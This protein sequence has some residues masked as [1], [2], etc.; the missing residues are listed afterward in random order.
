M[1]KSS[2]LKL[3]NNF[4]SLRFFAAVSVLYGHSYILYGNVVE[5]FGRILN[6]SI[7]ELGV[8]A[9]F[10]MSGFLI[11]GSFQRNRSIL[12]YIK[13]R[14]LRIIPALAFSTI[15]AAFIIGPIVTT[16]S[17]HDYFTQR[18][19]W[20]F[21]NNATMF[22]IRYYLPGVFTHNVYPGAVNGSLWTLRHELMMYICLPLL[23]AVGLISR[24][25]ILYVLLAFF[26]IHFKIVTNPDMGRY[27][28]PVNAYHF[29]D[30]GL[31]FFSGA[32]FYIYFDKI[33]F[34]LSLCL[35]STL[36]GILMAKTIYN[37]MIWHICL[38]YIIIFLAYYN[39]GSLRNFGKYGDF[40]Y[41][42][43]V[44]AFPIQQTLTFFYGHRINFYT[45]ISLVF[46]LTLIM[47]VISWHLIEKR[48]LSLKHK[49]WNKKFDKAH[50]HSPS[51]VKA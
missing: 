43:Y 17:L 7:S 31:Y 33:P 16:V 37:N 1:D 30:L 20:E 4:D 47:A 32:F 45:Y 22:Y 15:I 19:T 8:Y 40:S 50:Q 41:G 26:V 14:F 21:F 27:F 29:A 13:N 35:L 39:F 48:A 18:E 3:A 9:F 49:F 38:P 34:K 11:T 10:I 36:A 25:F 5:P 28:L 12:D 46:I 24:R 42:M 2:P 23:A 51:T 6:A 44:F